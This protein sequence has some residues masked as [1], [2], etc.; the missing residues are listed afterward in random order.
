MKKWKWK[1]LS[2]VQ[3]R[4][5]MDCI[6][7]GILQ[8]RTLEWAAF[9][10]TRASSQARGRTQVSCIADRFFYQLS[11]Q[12]SLN[13][14]NHEVVTS[15]NSETRMLK[16]ETWIYTFVC[17]YVCV[18]VKFSTQKVRIFGETLYDHKNSQKIT[19]NIDLTLKNS[20][21]VLFKCT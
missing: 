16:F 7:H 3:L 4:H 10:F 13:N 15:T 11:H 9:P 2:R 6:V 19:R 14:T 18:Y 5:P 8:A 12:E 1:S 21:S 17:M 20:A